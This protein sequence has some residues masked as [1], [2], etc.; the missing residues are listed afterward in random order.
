[1]K[2]KT[3]INKEELHSI[4]E[5]IFKNDEMS[6]NNLYENYKG[7]VYKIAFSILKNK[8]NSEEITQ[9]VFMKIW[10]IEKGKLPK[11][12]EA[13]WIY[14]LTKNEAL[15]FLRSKKVEQN[16]DD[17][18]YITSEDTEINEIIE[19]DSYNR[20]ISKLNLKEQEI[21]SLKI[22]SNLSFKQISQILNVPEGTVKWKYYKSMHTLK[23]LLGNLALF[24]ITFAVSIK[25]VLFDQRI[26]SQTAGEVED[27]EITQD[28]EIKEEQKNNTSS[29]S[30][31]GN[32]DII[33]Q[34]NVISENKT[35]ES[36]TTEIQN[37]DDTTQNVITENPIIMN[38]YY[39]IGILSVSAI[40]LVTTIIFT[41]IFVK[42]QLKTK[43]KASK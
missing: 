17:M 18:Y 33:I 22:I 10:E 36:A 31:K 6:F 16:I 13:S 5:G 3:K 19:Q 30:H 25:T 7:L 32:T 43:I 9:K 38:N 29:E 37:Q 28:T 42:H 41:V 27:S 24:I 2:E 15:N 8:E 34:E 23:L 11:K 20:I 4:F 1:M 21:V 39:K 14:T 40:F 35:Q 26:K 12:S